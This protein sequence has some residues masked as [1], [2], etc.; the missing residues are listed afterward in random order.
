M[1]PPS[2]T[3]AP[4]LEQNAP[5]EYS[6]SERQ[7]LCQ[8]AHEAVLSLLEE[9]GLREFTI[10]G[11]LSEPRGVFTTLYRKGKLRGCVGY[12]AAL[13][14]LHQAVVET[15]RAAAFDDPRFPA[16]TL[17]EAGE[18][19][20]SISVLGPVRPILAEEVEVGRHGLLISLGS[21]RGLLLPQ[22]ALENGWDRIKFLE[23]TCRKAGLEPDG[24]RTGAT[25]EAFT[26][27]VF[28]DE[29]KEGS[30]PD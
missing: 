27:E 7:M 3:L 20:V 14:P 15:A 28:G 17:V 25:I 12:P 6:A 13:M 18:L 5:P 26:A 9:R 2:D 1:P 16:L 11:H 24:W 30:T 22:V 8:L 10:S 21:R 23:Q 4:F 19:G 29:A